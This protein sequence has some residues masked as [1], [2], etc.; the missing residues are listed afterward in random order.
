[1][2]FIWYAAIS[3]DLGQFK[4]LLSILHTNGRIAEL[5]KV[6]NVQTGTN[7]LHIASFKNKIRVVQEIIKHKKI[8]LNA[9]TVDGRTALFIAS[10]MNHLDLV[11]LLLA[12]GNRFVLPSKPFMF[13]PRMYLGLTWHKPIFSIVMHYG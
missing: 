1:M 3:T 9:Q 11:D 13:L 10:E 8:D 6:G 5:N 7:P 2:S 4:R 12:Q